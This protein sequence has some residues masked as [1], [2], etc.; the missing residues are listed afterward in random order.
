MTYRNYRNSLHKQMM[1][2]LRFMKCADTDTEL[3]A[4]NAEVNLLRIKVEFLDRKTASQMQETV[5]FNE[6]TFQSMGFPDDFAPTTS[7]FI[8]SISSKID[9]FTPIH[10]KY[11]GINHERDTGCYRAVLIYKGKTLFEST[12]KTEDL[13]VKARDAA[14]LK[15]HLPN[16][17]HELK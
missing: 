10:S 4:L 5:N 12:F 11:K 9:D 6:H 2:Y 8:E 1:A 16:P 13:A 15:Y 7:N 14:I 17:L 3:L